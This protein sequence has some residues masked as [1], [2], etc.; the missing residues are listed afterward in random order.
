MDLPREQTD[1]GTCIS[2]LAHVQ[3][4]IHNSNMLG[5][6][7]LARTAKH[8]GNREY[9]DVARAAMEYSCSRQKADGS[10]PY[11][12]ARSYQW[13]DNF[14]TGYNLDS[15]K[16]YVDSTGDETWRPNLRSG[17]D[18]FLT[19]FF[20]SD[21]CPKYYHDRRYPID[22][23]CAAQAI[24]SLVS[25]AEDDPRCL[26][27]SIKVAR[28]TIENM[29]HRDGHFYYRIYPWM[30]AKTP[31]LHWAQAT[32]Y[33]ALAVLQNRLEANRNTTETEDPSG[34]RAVA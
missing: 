4:S 34:K 32:M 25:F 3:S 2:Y 11:G 1:R 31:M 28:W 26:P 9:L 20:E 22:S 12:E 16:A 5:A 23:Q 17:L 33:K 18:Y 8:T 13:V 19:H 24:E 10:W 7:M 21:G 6:A 14:H 15:L 29:Q 27:L 30:T